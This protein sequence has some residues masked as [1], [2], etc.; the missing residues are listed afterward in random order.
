[1][2]FVILSIIKTLSKGIKLFVIVLNLKMRKAQ[3]Q[4]QLKSS[5]CSE[6]TTRKQF[7]IKN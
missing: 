5:I 7:T 2:F 6:R 4:K 3:T 1:M